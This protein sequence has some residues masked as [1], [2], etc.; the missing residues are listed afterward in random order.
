MS[1]HPEAPSAPTLINRKLFKTKKTT[2][3]TTITSEIK[4]NNAKPIK[5]N[6]LKFAGFSQFL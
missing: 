2:T 5:T 6:K 4:Q 1:S 3:G